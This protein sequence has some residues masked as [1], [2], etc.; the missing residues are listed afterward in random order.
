MFQDSFGVHS[1]FVASFEQSLAIFEQS[2][3]EQSLTAF[4]LPTPCEKKLL[5]VKHPRNTLV[6]ELSF[7]HIPRNQTQWWIYPNS[8]STTA[9]FLDRRLNSRFPCHRW[10]TCM[11]RAM[12]GRV[13]LVIN[14]FNLTEETCRLFLRLLRWDKTKSKAKAIFFC[15]LWSL[16]KKVTHI[17][18]LNGKFDWNQSF[19]GQL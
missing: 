19:Q 2:S 9:C 17:D 15:K 11:D 7:G 6:C 1:V 12:F 16:A 8:H 4:S 3:F 5:A 14:P 10:T 18:I 13:T